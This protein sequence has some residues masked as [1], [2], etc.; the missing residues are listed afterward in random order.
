MRLVEHLV[1]RE[2]R[3]QLQLSPRQMQFVERLVDQGYRVE[4]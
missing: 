2:Y 3:V 1:D 4:L